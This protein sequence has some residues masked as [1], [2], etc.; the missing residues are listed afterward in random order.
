MSMMWPEKV[1]AV[2]QAWY[3]GN[4]SGNALSDIIYGIVNPGDRLPITLPA[5]NQDIPSY[6]N[7]GSENGKVRYREDLFVGYKHYEA[8]GI[9][10]LLPFGLAL[11]TSV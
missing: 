7:F 8:R 4:E 3:S 1:A 6:L 10:P 2:V 9:K 5:R 11:S